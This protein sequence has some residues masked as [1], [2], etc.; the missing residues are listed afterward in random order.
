MSPDGAPTTTATKMFKLGGLTIIFQLGL[1]CAISGLLPVVIQADAKL[2][3]N[4]SSNSDYE[5]YR[6][7]SVLRLKPQSYAQLDELKKLLENH[8]SVAS[9]QSRFG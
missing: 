6:G 8:V 9:V 7:Y 3:A 4:D 2:T 5:T 1:L